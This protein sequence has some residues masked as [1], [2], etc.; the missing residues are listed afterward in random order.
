MQTTE[1]IIATPTTRLWIVSGEGE[2][3][4]TLEYTGKRTLRALR[5]RLTRER[6]NGDRWARVEAETPNHGPWKLDI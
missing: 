4:F 6:C 1:Q 3:G 2:I 5:C